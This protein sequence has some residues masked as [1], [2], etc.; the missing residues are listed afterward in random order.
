MTWKKY[1]PDFGRSD[2]FNGIVKK[3]PFVSAVPFTKTIEAEKSQFVPYP[4]TAESA[5]VSAFFSPSV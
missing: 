4:K 2:G 1:D 3:P 5:E